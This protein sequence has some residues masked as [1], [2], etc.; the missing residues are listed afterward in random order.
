MNGLF[1]GEYFDGLTSR[2]RP[3]E[4]VVVG[5]RIGLRGEDVDLDFH[6]RQL[7]FRPRV[8]SAPLDVDLPNGGLLV[9]PFDDIA[10]FVAVPRLADLAHRLERHTGFVLAA[11]AGLVAAAWLA[12]TEGIPWLARV[13]AHRLPPA[14][15]ADIA[16]QGLAVL[17]ANVF[18]PSVLSDPY[19]ERVQQRLALL[20][21]ADG[22]A[23]PRLELRDGGFIGPN[24]FALPGGV[25]VVTDQ[26]VQLLDDDE[27][28]AVLAHELGHL[29]HRHGAQRILQASITG[30][31]TAAIFG[32]ISGGTLAATVPTTFL[33]SGYSRDL[34]RDADAYAF[35]LL[36]RA[37][38][39][40]RLLGAA[41]ERM[42]EDIDRH[43]PRNPMLRGSRTGYLAS[44]PL[45]AERMRAAEQAVV[46]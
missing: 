20:A 3:V 1:A 22:V 4:V 33:F 28:A 45:T 17:D 34:E 12:Y 2:R 40:P 24:A 31:L 13:V 9:A 8:G 37:G 19:R 42:Q 10:S 14:I 38:L 18:R 5:E 11:L 41:L 25:I 26:L 29:R 23:T 44:H 39:S 35:D 6:Q 32:D 27:V 30:L 16:R 7:R 21:A 36:R 46:R 15:E 43:R